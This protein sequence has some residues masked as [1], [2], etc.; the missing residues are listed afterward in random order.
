MIQEGDRV[1]VGLSGGKDSLTLLTLLAQ[2]S[3]FFPNKFEVAAATIDMGFPGADFTPLTQYCQRLGVPLFLKKTNLAEIIFDI[4]KEKNPC[5]LCA[6]MRRGALGD[7]AIENKYNKVALGHH[8]DDVVET[9][10]L[11]LFY[12]GRI[13]CFSPVTYLSRTNITQI[14][15]MIYIPEKEIIGFSRKYQTPVAKNP[16]PANTNTKRQYIKDLLKQ[17]Q[18]ENHG[19]KERTFGALQRGNISGFSDKNPCVL[20]PSQ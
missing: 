3:R 1:L 14:R 6:K 5:S 16:C 13:S 19:L 4:R 17:L 11:S 9:F 10:Y 2:L 8:N 15:P 18:R 12:E 20:P 7:I